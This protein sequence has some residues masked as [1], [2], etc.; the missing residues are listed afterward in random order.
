[1]SILTV[2][3]VMDNALGAYGRPIF[4]QSKGVALRS[5]I[6]EVNRSGAD[7]QMNQHPGDFALYVLG[8]FD[9]ETGAFEN[10]PGGPD[11]ICLATDVIVKGE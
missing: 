9:D 11:R 5:F 2:V 10:T 8:F 4:V 3:S 6:D 1:M 7:N